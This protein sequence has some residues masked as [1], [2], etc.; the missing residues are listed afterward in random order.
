MRVS[1]IPVQ[2]DL[3]FLH[4]FDGSCLRRDQ[5]SRQEPISQDVYVSVSKPL[6]PFDNFEGLVRGE[7]I[8]LIFEETMSGTEA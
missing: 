5:E 2:L 8:Y 1:G 7:D 6:T 3:V 4:I